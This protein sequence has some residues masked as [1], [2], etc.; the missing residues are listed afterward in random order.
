MKTIVVSSNF[1]YLT[2]VCEP[3]DNVYFH[4]EASTEQRK[5]FFHKRYLAV[6]KHFADC[7]II[8]GAGPTDALF[9]GQKAWH[10]VNKYP[11]L[12]EE[13]QNRLL[14]SIS[15]PVPDS[16]SQF[17]KK[18][19]KALPSEFYDAVK[20]F[21]DE[22]LNEIDYYF[23]KKKLPL[24]YFQSRNNLVGRDFSSKMSCFLSCGALDVKYLYNQIKSFEKRVGANKSTYWLIF[25]LLWR[26]FFYWHYQEHQRRFFSLNGIKGELNF[27]SFE[28]FNLVDLKKMSNSTF[29][30]SCLNELER[31]GYLSNRARQM[32]ASFWVN[33]LE[34]DWRS[35]AYLFEQ[36]LIDY[37]VFSNYGNWM[38]L[39]GVGVDPRG[40]RYFNIEKQLATYDPKGHYLKKWS[41]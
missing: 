16:F 36:Y 11:C 29:F 35:G 26:E 14:N 37:D 9:I 23:Y 24:T 39:A 25:E 41:Q 12:I 21:D 1:Y 15:F 8:L 32:F 2:R 33:D 10:E 22:V 31:T 38:Y 34:L 3:G 28:K 4:V 19:E 13:G 18:A 27:S 6:K 7:K 17:R 30:I 40:K 20:P 5:L